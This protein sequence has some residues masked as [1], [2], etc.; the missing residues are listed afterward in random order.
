MC[1]TLF[2]FHVN[3]F[4]IGLRFLS[5]FDSRLGEEDIASSFYQKVSE[6][7]QEIPQSHTSDQPFAP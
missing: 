4:V 1:F 6:Y 2:L 7:N 5:M 3:N